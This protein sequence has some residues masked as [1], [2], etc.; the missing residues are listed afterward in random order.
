[1]IDSHCHLNFEQFDEDRDQVLTNAAEVG[2]RRF[3]NPSIDLET[4]RR[5]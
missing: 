2:V 4:S 3:I 5:L 1:M